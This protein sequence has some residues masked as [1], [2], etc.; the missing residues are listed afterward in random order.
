MKTKL[1]ITIVAIALIG[2]GIF[3]YFFV[4]GG[5][6]TAQAQCETTDMIF[7]YQD[8][9]PACGQV[10]SDGSITKLETLGINI[11]SVE[12][13]REPA[14]SNIQYVPSFVVNGEVNSG[15]M[16]YEELKELLGCTE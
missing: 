5:E 2:G 14:P 4:I 15:Y 7:Y 16:T 9:C 10:K 8:G 6:N 12:T 3:L 11:K 1:I 13:G